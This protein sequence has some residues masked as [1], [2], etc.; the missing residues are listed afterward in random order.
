M[1]CVAR[2]E[3]AC[4]EQP[5][6]VAVVGA[7]ELE[8]L[9]AAGGGAGEPDRAHRRLGAGGGHPQHVDRR[10]ARA[11]P[12]SASS[13]SPAVGAPNVVPLRG[14][15]GDRREHR[16]VRVAVDQRAPRADVV[17]VDVAVDV[18]ELGAGGALDEDRVAPDRAHRAH[19]R[20]HAAGE[21]VQRP[22]VEL[23]RARVG[24]RGGAQDACSASQRLKSSVK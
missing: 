2:P 13:T 3:P 18:G 10:H 17:D 23:G 8:E 12:A 7:G 24:E 11:R 4:G 19:G 21:H 1:P 14:R 5:V 9:L 16:R 6:D 22:P 15:L 20:V